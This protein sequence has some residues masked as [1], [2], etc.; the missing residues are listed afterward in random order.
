MATQEEKHHI[1]D[2]K[3]RITEL[4]DDTRK[5]AQRW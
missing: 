2:G 4:M 3:F 5:V 1:H